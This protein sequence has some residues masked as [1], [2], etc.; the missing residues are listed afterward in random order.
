MANLWNAA[1]ICTIEP[2]QSREKQSDRK[3]HTTKRHVNGNHMHQH[4]LKKQKRQVWTH[5][6][7]LNTELHALINLA[8]PEAAENGSGRPGHT[9]RP[10]RKGLH[11]L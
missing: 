6:K 8:H 7:V 11:E 10:A 4:V 1:C 9:G 3:D 5:W 2:K